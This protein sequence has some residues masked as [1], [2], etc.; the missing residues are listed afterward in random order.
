MAI[1][2]NK[3]DDSSAQLDPTVEAQMNLV[4][5]PATDPQALLAEDA[6]PIV[7]KTPPETTHPAEDRK[8]KK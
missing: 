4:A 6:D 3:P 8:R 7:A 5:N 1:G 2:T